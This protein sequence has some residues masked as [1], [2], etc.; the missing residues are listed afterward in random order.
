MDVELLMMLA[1]ATAQAS[2]FLETVT[3]CDLVVS[4]IG[5]RLIEPFFPLPA[6]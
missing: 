3:S 1:I 5:L 6:G 2:H 4:C